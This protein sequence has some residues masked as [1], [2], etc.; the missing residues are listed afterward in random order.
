MRMRVRKSWGAQCETEIVQEAVFH[1]EQQ[2]FQ[3]YYFSSIFFSFMSSARENSS[4][5]QN[6]RQLK[7][8]IV[9]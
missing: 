5:F 8:V 2:L 4:L 9:L 1:E 7:L 3:R 6:F